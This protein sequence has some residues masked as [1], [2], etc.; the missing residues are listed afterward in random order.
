MVPSLPAQHIA[1]LLL[2]GENNTSIN[3]MSIRLNKRERN[4]PFFP[5]QKEDWMYKDDSID[6]EIHVNQRGNC[7]KGH[8][9]NLVSSLL[10]ACNVGKWKVQDRREGKSPTQAL[11]KLTFKLWHPTQLY[12]CSLWGLRK[13]YRLLG[14][15][16]T[17]DRT[18]LWGLTAMFPLCVY[19]QITAEGRGWG[20]KGQYLGIHRT[21]NKCH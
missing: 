18:E 9:S 5:I 15:G 10:L 17:N 1:S 14:P 19:L 11:I 6:T 21:S 12:L 16:P 20:M 2:W 7:V 8:A 3:V 13:G 4:P